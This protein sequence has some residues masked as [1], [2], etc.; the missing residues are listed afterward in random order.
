MAKLSE[1]V[2]TI[3]ILLIVLHI[4]PPIIRNI[5]NQYSSFLEPQTQVGSLAIKGVL[6][7]STYYT[8]SLKKF[9]ENKEIKAILLT[10]ESAGG[11]SGTAESIA[12]E[13]DLLKK[14]HP[15]PI[16][17]YAENFCTSGA[18]YIATATD[19]IIT[20][21]SCLIGDI[22]ATIPAQFKIHYQV[23]K[24]GDYKSAK[25]SFNELTPEQK[26]LLQGLANSSHQNF[27]EQVKTHRHNLPTNTQEWSSGQLFTGLQALQMKLIDEIGSQSNAIKKIKELGIIEGNI[28]WVKPEKSYSIWNMIFGQESDS[29]LESLTNAIKLMLEH[30]PAALCIQH[31][32]NQ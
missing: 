23:I 26:T 10:I 1:L 31:N 4:A 2:K 19:Y 5:K 27:I 17:C 30:S 7:D 24:S 13:I 20:A 28:E 14:E 32:N 25:D 6:Y 11:A 18:Y 15:K 22:G 9:F 29:G 16:I 12:H 21:P 8:T 3:F